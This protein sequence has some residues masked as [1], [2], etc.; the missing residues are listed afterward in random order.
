MHFE[1]TDFLLLAGYLLGFVAVVEVGFRL[2]RYYNKEQSM[3]E[4][5]H[6]TALQSSLLGLLSLLLGFNFALAGSRFDSRNDLLQEEAALIKICLLKTR[7]LPPALGQELQS[8][9]R[10]YADARLEDFRVEQGRGSAQRMPVDASV[11]ESRLW[12]LVAGAAKDHPDIGTTSLFM[13]SMND[14]VRVREK[15]DAQTNNHVPRLVNGLLLTVAAGSLGFISFTSGL[16]GAR[17]NRATLAY[18]FIIALLLMTIFDLD[19]ASS[20]FI[21]VNETPLLEVQKLLSG[22]S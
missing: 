10:S 22:A 11:S 5:S 19:Q 9:L 8:A 21:Q 14:L 17:R 13:P 4:R 3:A 20:G 1:S 16:V 18:S 2:G 7:F 15:R 6:L 12:T